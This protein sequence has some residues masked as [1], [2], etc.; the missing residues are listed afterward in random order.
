MLTGRLVELRPMEAGDL[1]FLAELSNHTVV[2]THVVDWH[3]PVV[4]DA[5]REWFQRAAADQH[6]RRLTVVDP[7]SREPVGLTGLW[8]VDWHNRSALSAIKLMPGRTPRG[9]GTDAL[10]LVMAWAFHEVGLRRLHT[11]IL[12]FNAASLGVYVRK[13][14]WRVEGRERESVFRG[15]R[16]CDLFHVA[17]LRP[18]FAVLPDAAEYVERV[19][20]PAPVPT[21]AQRDSRSGLPSGEPWTAANPGA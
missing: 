16:W 1:P 8:S 15:G 7:A 6:T 9:A 4:P 21:P 14:G 12:D 13:C 19:C 3:W 20:G 18:D 17:A 10:M 11:T 5:Q 2:R